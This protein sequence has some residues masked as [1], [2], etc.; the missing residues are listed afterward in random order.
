MSEPGRVMLWSG[1][2]FT[3][4]VSQFV[5][6][7]AYK[8][9][10]IA[11]LEARHRALAEEALSYQQADPWA[12]GARYEAGRVIRVIVQDLRTRDIPR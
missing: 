3:I 5:G 10:L 6:W 12:S 1:W 9:P 4:L 2:I 8:W 7:A 11:F